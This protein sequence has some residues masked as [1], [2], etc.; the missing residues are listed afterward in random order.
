MNLSLNKSH[1]QIHFRTDFNLRQ[2]H[3]TTPIMILI[4]R[5]LRT[6]WYGD[7][8]SGYYFIY[9]CFTLL[10]AFIDLPGIDRNIRIRTFF[11]RRD[12][13]THEWSVQAETTTTRRKNCSCKLAL[14][15][16]VFSFWLWSANGA[17]I[18]FAIAFDPKQP[19]K[20]ETICFARSH[21]HGCADRIQS[22][23]FWLRC[24]CK[25]IY[26]CSYYKRI[27]LIR[28]TWCSSIGGN[29]TFW[30]TWLKWPLRTRFNLR[31]IPKQVLL[32]H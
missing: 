6:I 11:M 30:Y 23:L 28:R 14:P 24:A 29:H 7:S 8:C 9:S 5:L 4:S 20:W 21:I 25:H 27:R 22:V 10:L 3:Y 17:Q 15:I 31:A 19:T 1:D 16:V 13:N 26:Q 12:S 32:I 18:V 2:Q